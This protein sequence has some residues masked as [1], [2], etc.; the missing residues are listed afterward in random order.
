MATHEDVEHTARKLT[1][2]MAGFALL[3]LLL[4]ALGCGE[5]DAEPVEELRQVLAPPPPPLPSPEQLHFQCRLVDCEYDTVERI[6]LDDGR[7][8]VVCVW[9]C[10]GGKH[11]TVTWLREPGEGS[12]FYPVAHEVRDWCEEEDDDG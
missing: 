12:C 2:L 7:D 6:Q 1:A 11:Y 8:R 9:P 5:Y 10:Y 3:A 4:G